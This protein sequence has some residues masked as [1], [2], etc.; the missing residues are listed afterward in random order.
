MNY[1][2]AAVAVLQAEQKFNS[3]SDANVI[4]A[5]ATKAKAVN[6]LAALD[7]EGPVSKNAAAI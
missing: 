4:E 3:A 6:A 2:C 5:G 7:K 1:I